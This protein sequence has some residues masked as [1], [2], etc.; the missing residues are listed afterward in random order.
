M[1]L[2]H[3]MGFV[4]DLEAL[5]LVIQLF[6]EDSVRELIAEEGRENQDSLLIK[7]GAEI[8]KESVRRGCDSVEFL[9]FL[10]DIVG[11]S[12]PDVL[13]PHGN[14]L[15]H[16][17][18]QKYG[19][20]LSCADI[21]R[22]S[23]KLIDWLLENYPSLLLMKNSKGES[24]LALAM[25]QGGLSNPTALYLANKVITAVRFTYWPRK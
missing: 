8:L 25:K 7:L 4:I 5:N 24:A 6:G 3:M 10:L 19:N 22:G 15:L 9:L 13:Y 1:D 12:I 14:T 11:L 20:A 2:K 23:S 21:F 16:I 17:A 18:A